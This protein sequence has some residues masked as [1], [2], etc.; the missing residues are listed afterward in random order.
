MNTTN[1][2]IHHPHESNKYE[3]K[4]TEKNPSH[5]FRFFFEETAGK[6]LS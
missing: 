3:Y 5:D 4:K 1:K 2:I 6:I